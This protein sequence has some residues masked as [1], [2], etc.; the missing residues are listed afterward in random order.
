MKFNTEGLFTKFVD[1][2]KII[3]VKGEIN[4][5][6]KDL[7]ISVKTKDTVGHLLQQWLKHWMI[8]S[9]INFKI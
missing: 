9:E 8:G 2:H 1:D 3:G 4:F 5:R 7:T 6:L